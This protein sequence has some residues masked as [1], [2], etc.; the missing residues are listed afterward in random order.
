MNNLEIWHLKRFCDKHGLDYQLIDDSLT[1]AENKGYLKT[2]RLPP[3][4][5]D[6]EALDEWAD[7]LKEARSREEQ[8]RREHILVLYIMAA[9]AGE[10]K[11]SEVGTHYYPRFSLKRWISQKHSPS[12]SGV[13]H[14]DNKKSL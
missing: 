7:F 5:F 6:S 11:S 14:A 13:K 1:Y 4:L 12:F 2:L 8:V 10:T 9:H 3:D